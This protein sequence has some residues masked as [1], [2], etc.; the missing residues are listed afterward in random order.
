MTTTTTNLNA[1]EIFFGV[2]IETIAPTALTRQGLIVGGYH[3]PVQVPFL[4]EGWKASYD[5]SIH[6]T[7]GYMA[8]EIVSPK[9]RG[10]NGLKQIADVCEIL[11]AKGFKVNSSTGVHVSVDF[12]GAS[13]DEKQ[14]LIQTVAFC[15][16]GIYATTGTHRRERGIYCQSVHNYGTRQDA[17]ARIDSSY[18]GDR[19]HI[20]NLTNLYNGQNRVEFRAFSGSLNAKKISGWVMMC[21]GLVQ[22]ARGNKRMPKWTGSSDPAWVAKRLGTNGNGQREFIRIQQFLNW[23]PALRAKKTAYG[24]MDS[25]FGFDAIQAELKRLAKKYA[26]NSPRQPSANHAPG[27]APGGAV[28]TSSR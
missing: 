26:T 24:M 5:C 1:N 20:L 28:L 25:E 3:R 14:R 11:T 21:V 4:P 9:L 18:H 7:R 27:T 6:T 23:Q 10:A 2:E 19:Y 15:E 16:K 12:T 13:N 8:C 17:A 22:R